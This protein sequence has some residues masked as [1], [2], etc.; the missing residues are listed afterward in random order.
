LWDVVKNR[1]EVVRE[2]FERIDLGGF[3]PHGRAPHSHFK[4]IVVSL[5]VSDEEAV[6]RDLI[7]AGARGV[8][9][10]VISS[11]CLTTA[12]EMSSPPIVL[13][14]SAVRRLLL[15]M[16]YLPYNKQVKW[17]GAAHRV[18]VTNRVTTEV[19]SLNPAQVREMLAATDLEEFLK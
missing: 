2:F 10:D 5:G 1:P 13:Q 4:D 14:T 15:K 19:T 12:L 11:A 8:G 18:W 3:N 16:G 9:A 7:A 17:E 6:T